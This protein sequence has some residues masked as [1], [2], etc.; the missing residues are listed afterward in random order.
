MKNKFAISL[1]EIRELGTAL[2]PPIAT[3]SIGGIRFDVYQ[4]KDLF[5]DQWKSD[6]LRKLVVASRTSY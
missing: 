1:N 6:E 3:R 2:P 4:A 5:H